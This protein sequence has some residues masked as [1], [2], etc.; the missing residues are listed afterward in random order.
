MMTADHYTY[1]VAWSA[2]DEEFVGL[3]AGF[4]SLSW[5]APIRA[6]ALGGI[7]RLVADCAADMAASSE[8]PTGSS[9]NG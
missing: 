3:C 8:P 9:A 5:L 1:R 7:R 2:E 4:L 6:E